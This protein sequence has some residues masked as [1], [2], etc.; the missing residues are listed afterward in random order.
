MSTTV[1]S[2][3]ELHPIRVEMPDEAVTDLR[4]RVAATR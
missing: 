3:S 1:E 4:Q 2:A